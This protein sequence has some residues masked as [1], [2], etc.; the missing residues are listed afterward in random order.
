MHTIVDIKRVDISVCTPVTMVLLTLAFFAHTCRFCLSVVLS[1]L[2]G[3]GPLQAACLAH[4]QVS[5]DSI[6]TVGGDERMPG[7]AV[8]SSTRS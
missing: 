5:I 6:S 1:R 8:A 3:S 4:C 2:R 7:E